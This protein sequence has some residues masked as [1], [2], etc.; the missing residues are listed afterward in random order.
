MDEHVARDVAAHVADAC[1]GR[2]VKIHWFGGEPLCNV[3]AIDTI[4]RELG[5]RGIAYRSFMTSNGFYLD[6]ELATR[7]KRDWHLEHVQITLDGTEDVYNRAKAYVDVDGSAYQRVLSNVAH[8]LDAGIRVFVRL[9]MDAG[10]VGE[11]HRVCDELAGRFGTRAGLKVLVVPLA[12]LAG[13]VRAFAS[14]AERA[15]ACIELNEHIDALGLADV[16]R[17]PRKLAAN[18]CQA[19]SASAEVILPDGQVACCEHIVETERIGDIYG[20]ERDERLVASWAWRADD[21]AECETCPI[22]PQCIRLVRCAWDSVTCSEGRKMLWGYMLK[23][24]MVA[25][26]MR[27]KGE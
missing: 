24:Q 3:D 4:S 26:Y 12:D 13:G 20:P 6:E 18:R 2:G 5:A 25:E 15:E 11:L 16:G 17:L 8:A 14:S 1:Q 19:D 9:N 27:C 23:R 10:N 21:L 22:Y 7:A